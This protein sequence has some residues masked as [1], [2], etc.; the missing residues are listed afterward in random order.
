[1]PN[2][3]GTPLSGVIAATSHGCTLISACITAQTSGLHFFVC[4]DLWGG[5]DPQEPWDPWHP[6]GSMAP[7]ESI[8]TMGSIGLMESFGSM[9]LMQ[10]MESTESMVSMGPM[11]GTHGIAIAPHNE[12]LW[13]NLSGATTRLDGVWADLGE[14]RIL[15]GN[16]GP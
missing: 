6:L 10:S 9:E 14:F 16:V 12:Q 13:K 5:A 11:G 8:G 1:M 3:S 7:M 15:S 4:Q 2:G